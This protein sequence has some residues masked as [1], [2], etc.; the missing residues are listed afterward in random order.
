MLYTRVKMY[1]KEVYKRKYTLPL[2]YTQKEDCLF[3]LITPD[4]VVEKGSIDSAMTGK[5]LRCECFYCSVL[6]DTQC[7]YIARR[8]MVFLGIV[9]HFSVV[10]TMKLC[11]LMNVDYKYVR[12]LKKDINKL[13]LYSDVSST[14]MAYT[15]TILSIDHVYDTFHAIDVITGENEAISKRIKLA[16]VDLFL[17]YSLSV[18]VNDQIVDDELELSD[19]VMGFNCSLKEAIEGINDRTVVYYY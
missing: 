6:F 9:R 19:G 11:L 14:S 5:H 10:D 8:L 15:T 2:A 13:S 3:R 12:M 16:L 17:L 4:E 1:G 18:Q 7:Y